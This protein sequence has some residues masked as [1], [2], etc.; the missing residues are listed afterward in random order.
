M[1]NV[2]YANKEGYKIQS[3]VLVLSN[4]KAF[5]KIGEILTETL[6]EE[7][8]MSMYKSKDTGFVL[9]GKKEVDEKDFKKC[10][11]KAIKKYCSDNIDKIC[12]LLEDRYEIE[13]DDD[14]INL[15]TIS[16][17]FDINISKKYVYVD[18]DA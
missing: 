12:S 3:L 8:S 9:K 16:G 17:K 15:D 4:M 11:I 7:C 5:P 2:K 14:C 18:L 6:P 10:L 1:K 13:Y